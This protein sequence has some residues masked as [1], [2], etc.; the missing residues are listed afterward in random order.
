MAVT[1][2]TLEYFPPALIPHSNAS[3]YPDHMQG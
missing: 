1:Q 3:V 2:S